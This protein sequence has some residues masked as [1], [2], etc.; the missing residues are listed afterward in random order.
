M[1]ACIAGLMD[2]GT[3][4]NI[5]IVAKDNITYTTLMYANGKHA[6]AN[7]NGTVRPNVTEEEAGKA[8]WL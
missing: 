7:E 4:N 5:P 8:T 1:F 3:G 2:D 6:V